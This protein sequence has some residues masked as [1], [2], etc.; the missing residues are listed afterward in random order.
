MSSSRVSS[1]LLRPLCCL[2]AECGALEGLILGPSSLLCVPLT[3]G[4][5]L[6][7]CFTCSSRASNSHIRGLP[8]WPGPGA[9]ERRLFA[10]AHGHRPH[11][12]VQAV[13]PG[14]TFLSSSPPHGPV[15]LTSRTCHLCLWSASYIGLPRLV[16]LCCEP[17]PGSYHHLFGWLASHPDWSPHMHSCPT[18]YSSRSGHRVLSQL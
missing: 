17:S 4:S 7:S 9:P 13:D 15:Q 2:A 12:G 6:G 10:S 1:L 8:S 5:C 18:F 3:S 14:F 16:S 11:S